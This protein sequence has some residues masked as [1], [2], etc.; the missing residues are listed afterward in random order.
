MQRRIEKEN[1]SEEPQM[2]Q[3]QREG[4][5]TRPRRECVSRRESG[6][7]AGERSDQMRAEECPW[8]MRAAPERCVFTTSHHCDRSRA[9]TWH[10][11]HSR[12]PLSTDV[13]A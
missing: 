9:C 4:C 13:S 1:S 10:L 3:P 8:A 7:S 2:E 5:V 11:A 12:C 6:S